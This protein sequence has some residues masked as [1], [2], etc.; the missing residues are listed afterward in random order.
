MIS[1]FN[2]SRACRRF[3]S[4]RPVCSARP[5]IVRHSYLGSSRARTTTALSSGASDSFEFPFSLIT[6]SHLNYETPY[7]EEQAVCIHLRL[8]TQTLT[9]Q[10]V[11]ISAMGALELAHEARQRLHRFERYGVVQRD[12]HAAD[13]AVARRADQTG[14]CGFCR[15][16]LLDGFI[17]A[18]H[19]KDHVHPRTRS[20]LY[21]AGVISAG[22]D[23]V[24][25]Q[26]G[27]G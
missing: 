3:A 18:G 15:E 1:P 21:R 16:F 27:L 6:P 4:G 7:G 2:S 9:G 26:L 8:L 24:I 14:G 12:A 25:Q 11:C 22:V 20:L 13:R 5:S 19:S 23:R 10:I 17:S